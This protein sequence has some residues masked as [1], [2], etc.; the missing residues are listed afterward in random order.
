MD[1]SELKIAVI[2]IHRTD[3]MGSTKAFADISVC[4]SFVINSLRVREGENGLFVAMPKE[5]GRN[6]R[7]Y[8]AVIP[9]RRDVK[10]EIERVVLEAYYCLNDI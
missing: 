6:G 8:F 7:W 10:E 4:D 3:E 1:V 5:E 2:R 9:L